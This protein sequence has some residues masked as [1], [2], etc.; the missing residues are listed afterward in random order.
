MGAGNYPDYLTRLVRSTTKNT[1]NGQDEESFTDGSSYWCRVEYQSGKREVLMGGNQTGADVQ[2]FVRNAP[3][4]TALDRFTD[5]E[6]TFVIDS[7]RP[8]TDE[9]ICDGYYLDS[10]VLADQ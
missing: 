6:T 5:G 9:L 2:I 8:G 1:N 3:E 7:V 4:L 10:L